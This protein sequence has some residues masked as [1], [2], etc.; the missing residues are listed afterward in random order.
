ME[1]SIFE[2][3]IHWTLEAIA[4]GM[5]LY[6]HETYGHSVYASRSW[7]ILWPDGRMTHHADRP[8]IDHLRRKAYPVP[9]HVTRWKRIKEQNLRGVRILNRQHVLTNPLDESVALVERIRERLLSPGGVV[10]VVTQLRQTVYD[11]PKYADWFSPAS[12]KLTGVYVR[13][14]KGKV[15]VFEGNIRFGWYK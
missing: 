15:F 7:M 5:G 6:V 14:G 2:G 10:A 4:D 12:D 13:Q 9:S 11:K 1:Q 3:S 8:S